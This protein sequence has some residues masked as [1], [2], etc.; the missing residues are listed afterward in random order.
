MK[1][2]TDRVTLIPPSLDQ[3]L[4]DRLQPIVES[5]S[6]LC[7]EVRRLAADV[8]ISNSYIK[9]VRIALCAISSLPSLKTENTITVD[10]NPVS[11][12]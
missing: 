12:P 8:E 9:E 7:F 3:I 11:V 10:N 5:I 1:T 2:K 4:E 6:S